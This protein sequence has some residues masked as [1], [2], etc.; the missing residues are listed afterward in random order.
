MAKLAASEAAARA[1]RVGLQVHGAIGYTW[2]QD[3]HIWMRRAWSLA[4]AWGD[5]AYHRERVTGAV[6]SDEARLGPGH[7][8]MGEP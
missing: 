8:F 3:L 4:L 7:T 6:L 1:A 2:E 5:E